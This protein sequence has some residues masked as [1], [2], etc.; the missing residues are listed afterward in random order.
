MAHGPVSEDCLYLNVWTAAASAGDKRP[1]FVW[2]HGGGFNEGSGAIAAY[3]G[4]ELAKKGLVVVTVNYRMGVL[5]FLSHPELTK[6]SGHQTS[7]NYGLLDQL[8]ALEWVKKNIVGFGGD[9][10]RVTIA[11]Q[12]AGAS[13]VHALAASPLARGLFQR[14]IA[15]S[16]SGL[17]RPL[18]SRA[19]AEKD[20]VRFAAAEGASS[21]P[22][23]RA[24]PV[25]E[26]TARVQGQSFGF[27]PIV[28]G[29]LLPDDIQT[30][31]ASGKQN[32]VPTLTG[33]VWDEGSSSAT[34]GKQTP[35]D[36]EQST[37]K[38]FG[39]FGD[40]LL[41]L[42]PASS[43]QSQTD[44]QRER[45]LLSMHLWAAKRAQTSKTRVFTYIF[46]H[47]EPGANSAIYRVFHTS[48]VPYVFKSLAKCDRPWTPDDRRIAEL[49]SSYWI[50][51]AT[52]GDPNGKGLPPWPAFDPQQ[53]RTMEI[54][55]RTGA[56]PIAEKSKVQLLSEYFE[57]Q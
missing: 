22:A 11:G 6:E 37:Q 30:L 49:V 21:L 56:I 15:E 9:P 55:D 53:L 17:G 12:S 13:S 38:A 23:L 36:F 25:S 29:W 39:P 46:D 7:G 45:A 41:K 26:I 20:G 16:G 40:R 52:T 2:I 18:G 35:A 34:Y 33:I 57:K 42:Y 47:P 51:F 27:R 8:A 3:D 19:E 10:G 5:G 54:G 14:A 28:D 43:P 1:V 44:L 50:N 32:D 48:E 4:E 24:L 31:F